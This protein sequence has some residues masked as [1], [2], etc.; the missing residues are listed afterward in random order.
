MGLPEG[1]MAT[2]ISGAF[3]SFSNAFLEFGTDATET[4]RSNRMRLLDRIK[5]S[6]FPE[7]VAPVES[8][9]PR[10]RMP[11]FKLTDAADLSVLIAP[12]LAEHIDALR[13]YAC[14]QLQQSQRGDMGQYFTPAPVARLMA[15][16]L[17]C[18]D[19]TISILDAG[20]GAGSLFAAAVA[21]LCDRTPCPQAIHVTAYE[22]EPSLLTYLHKS[23]ELCKRICDR[24]GITFTSEI[25]RADFLEEASEI[26]NGNMFVSPL[27]AFTTAILNPPYRKINAESETRHYL[28]QAGVETSNLYTGFLAL[29]TQ[30]LAPHGEIVAITPRSFC[31]GTYFRTF[32]EAFLR[33]M[34]L[35]QLHLF[36]SRQ[37]AFRDDA[38]LQ[39]T[40]ILHAEKTKKTPQHVCV[41]SSI[42]AEDDM[43][44]SRTLPYSEVVHPNDPERFI[45]LVQDS[46]DQHVVNCMA[47]FSK[48][49]SDLGLMVST[50]RVVDF[51]A[52]A[53]LREQPE[54]GDAPL[55]Y[56]VNLQNGGIEWPKHCRKPQALLVCKETESLLLPNE[57]YVLVKRF[58]SK[59]QTRRVI[60]AVFKGGCLSGNVVGFENH[61]NYFH[62]A[63][64]GL[65][66]ALAPF[67]Q[68]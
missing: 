23:T 58:T 10:E 9:I 15:S 37:D 11:I 38:V 46:A 25:R 3:D 20:A 31:N 34:A 52:K 35:R 27:P 24:A 68:R 22:I 26:L 47:T 49:L 21:E 5:P 66:F 60:S 7:L 4:E 18:P 59:E 2:T 48:S 17:K 19:S 29:A 54:L 67:H 14:K 45:R 53:Y 56:P 16:M 57:N 13:L 12:D 1:K 39:E 6:R 50:G 30:L 51:R 28:R 64:K 63:G 44:R 33:D 43:I 65:D 62:Q 40:I 61:L 55:V 41:T 36:D 32:R 42:G 8:V